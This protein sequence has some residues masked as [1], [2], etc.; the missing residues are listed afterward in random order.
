M[1]RYCKIQALGYSLVL[2]V[3]AVPAAHSSISFSNPITYSAGPNPSQVITADF[4]G[5]R[6]LDMAVLNPA[7]SPKNTGSVAILLGLGDGILHP[8]DRLRPTTVC[9]HCRLGTICRTPVLRT[10]KREP[11]SSLGWLGSDSQ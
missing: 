4:N 3:M 6:K 1:R 11:E 9:M 2:L 5:D 7:I 8:D 10:S